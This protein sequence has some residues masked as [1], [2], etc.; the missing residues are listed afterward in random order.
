MYATARNN[1][2]FIDRMFRFGVLE[3]L[4]C[5]EVFSSNLVGV[6]PAG[7][8]VMAENAFDITPGVKKD[9]YLCISPV[10]IGISHLRF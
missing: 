2:E 7:Q 9:C 4:P 1:A 3:W 6:F 10:S 5:K 8:G